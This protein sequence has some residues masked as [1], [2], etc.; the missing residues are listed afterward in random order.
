MAL[1]FRI[2]LSIKLP[3]LTLGVLNKVSIHWFH[4]SVLPCQFSIPIYFYP[5]LTCFG[6][7]LA[8][9]HL[10]SRLPNRC[11]NMVDCLLS[12]LKLPTESL[13]FDAIELPLI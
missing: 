11:S 1:K 13:Q 9:G 5:Q 4:F 10:S 3:E 8:L 12:L 2:S 6:A 7:C